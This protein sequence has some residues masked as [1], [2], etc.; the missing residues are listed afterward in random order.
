MSEENLEEDI[1]RLRADRKKPLDVLQTL[2]NDTQTFLEPGQETAT[3][4][5]SRIDAI[6]PGWPR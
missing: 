6:S 5:K 1:K 4:V 3:I 2:L